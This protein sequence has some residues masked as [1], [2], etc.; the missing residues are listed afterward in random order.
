MKRKSYLFF[1][2]LSLVF[3]SC[4]T[5]STKKIENIIKN[6]VYEENENDLTI[7]FPS[8][9]DKKGKIIGGD[10]T[11]IIFPDNTC[12][13][14]DGFYPKASKKYIQFIKNLGI[15]KIDNLVVSHFHKDHIGTFLNI[16][17]EFEV[18]RIYTNGGYINS[19]YSNNLKKKIDEKNIDEI[20]LKEG[21]EFDFADCK[22]KV[23]SPNLSPQN[24]YDLYYNPGRT[25]ELINNSSLVFKMEYNNFSILF[26]GDVYKQR[27]KELYLKY[28]NQLKSNVL[29]VPHHGDSKRASSKDFISAVDADYGIILDNRYYGPKI[30]EKY[31]SFNT[32]L[33][34]R[35]SE[36]KIVLKTDGNKYFIESINEKMLI[37]NNSKKKKSQKT[38]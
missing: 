22:F 19:K 9:E 18:D 33:L 15:K 35:E 24:I 12:M 20:I 11:V 31:E 14:I 13:I 36:G 21:D 10:G 2:F 27:D 30:I 28:G 4:K 23:F 6:E 5:K 38:K 3:I 32:E 25:S 29:K 7:Y 1:I 26:T 34:C 16:L 17:D 8:F 37:N